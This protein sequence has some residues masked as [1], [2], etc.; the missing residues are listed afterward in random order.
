MDARR[1]DVAIIGMA[2]AFPGAGN[3]KAYWENILAGVD[4]ITDAP[5]GSA[6]ARV[7]DPDTTGNDRLYTQKG[8]YLGD[9]LRFDPLAFG[10][11]PR[12]V[13]GGE[14]EHF[15]ALKLAHDALADAGYLERPFNRKACG[16]ILGRGTYV[17][18]GVI[19]CFQH[20]IVV[21]E[22][23]SVLKRLHPEHSDESI[24]AIRRSLKDS[25]P[26]FNPETAPG[27]AHSV[28]VGRIANRLDLMGP[29]YTV[30]AACASSLI[31]LD[32]AM[33]DLRS[34][35]CDMVL[36]GGVQISSTYPVALLFT[37]LGALARSGRIRPFHPDADGTLLG[38][39]A[40]VVLLKRREDAERD[41]DRIYAVVK[42][43]GIASDGKAMGILAPRVEG[44][45]L[46]M[47]RAYETTGVDPA[48]VGLV[49]AHGTGTPVGDATEI[50][51]LRRVFGD[52]DGTPRVPIGS[53]K[54][55]IGHCIPAA[56]VAGL[57]KAALAV[58]HRIAPPTLHAATD[59]PKLAGSRFYPNPAAR[60]WIHAGPEPRRAAV[61]AFGFG[62][63][64]GHAI[65]EEPGPSVHATHRG[66]PVAAVAAGAAVAETPGAAA[67][68]APYAAIAPG[69][70]D[71]ETNLHARRDTEIYLVRAADRAALLRRLAA[72]RAFIAANPQ[73]RPQ[74]VAYTLN[75]PSGGD[76]AAG[77]A[78]AGGDAPGASC[79]ATVADSLAELD[80]KLAH[81]GKRL[82]D[83]AC[84]RIKEKSG[85]Y[86]FEERLRE[87]GGL[88]FLF[89][90]EGAQYPGMLGDLC[91]HFPE[92]RAWFD[93]MDGAFR[94]HRRGF[95]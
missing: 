46:A 13:D 29:A 39:G 34:G 61:S 52:G 49:E 71:P 2:C 93:L 78:A 57:I 15:L 8:G 6:T 95:V 11:M 58:H 32:C 3:L 76:V 23:V 19:S 37:Q 27:L 51:A 55:M 36:A 67:A 20:T 83:P 16:V 21:D 22:V 87:Q 59:H 40:G 72:V 90:G 79:L 77:A 35:A 94:D 25:L 75:C 10:V 92:A 70:S 84:H 18:R 12:S 4:A 9:L 28:M 17:N 47:R 63:I 91:L 62:G 41:G 5:A 86:W 68:E 54:S 69:A 1:S 89:P 33:R 42:G 43:V 26:P 65:L 82:A 30:D 48:S 81:A 74:D 64:N 31:A 73:T 7:F 45:E 85:I 53:V 66:R 44:E 60:P 80:R 56:A 50:E 14:P 88:A 24:A 38:E